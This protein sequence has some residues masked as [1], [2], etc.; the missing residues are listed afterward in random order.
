[1]RGEIELPLAIGL[2]GGMTRAHPVAQIALQIL[3]VQSARE[4][5]AVMAAVGLAQNLGALRALAAEG[6]QAGH[7]KL[8]ARRSKSE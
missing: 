6:I 1:L 2:V 3:G 5:A 4:L 8:H 7:M